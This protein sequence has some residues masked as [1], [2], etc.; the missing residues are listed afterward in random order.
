MA[1]V[2]FNY[3]PGS[4]LIAPGTFFEVNSA[5]KYTSL[6]RGL[7]F[8]IKS[9][10]GTATADTPVICSTIEEAAQLAGVG[11]QLY[12]TFRQAR[13]HAPVQE[14]WI[15]PIPVTGAAAT[16]TVTIGTLNANGGDYQLEIA[17]RILR[18]TVAAG[19]A[20]ATTATNLAAAINAFVDKATLA[21]LPVTAG[22]ATNV[23]TLTARHAGVCM[24]EVEVYADANIAGNI[25]GPV[26]AVTIAA[27]T[28]GTGTPS[29]T[30]IV[31]ALG[32]E[33]FDWWV[34]PF[35]DATNVAITEAALSDTT[36]R[37][38]YATQLYGHSFAVSTNNLAGHVSYGLARNS[39][40]SSG[41]AWWSS[42]TP[43]WEALA[44]YVG[45]Q[46]PWLADDT[47]GNAAR[48]QSDRV[49]DGVR[50]PRSRSTWPNYTSRNSLNANG[51]STFKVNSVGEVCVDKCITHNRLNGAGQP[52]SVFRNV[53]AIA[54]AT[55]GLRYLRAMISYRHANK[56]LALANP[57]NL[58]AIS[59]PGDIRADLVEAYGDLVDRG[60]F[61]DK[62]SFAKALVV[63]IDGTNA[64]RVNAGLNMALVNPL[65]IFAANATIWSQFRAA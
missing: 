27:G 43:S 9:A 33:A 45:V 30:N 34:N 46:M 11:S 62:A 53:Q 16:W 24:N 40:H 3:I 54:C 52:D 57:G 49:L 26:G 50:A 60:L 37:W 21:Y 32:D 55:H 15:A 31:G 51:M 41:L 42:P 39:R 61:Q 20:A 2:L 12:E 6:S 58:P 47:N 10:A 17:G 7:I 29:L 25:F 56:A 5:G 28:A 23:V 36:G 64:S 65:D 1:G 18:G 63:E 14:L 44:A 19:E 13:R 59:T 22:A 48:N 4:G 38:S 8:G 35:G